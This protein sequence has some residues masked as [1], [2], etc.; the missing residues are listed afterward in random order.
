MMNHIDRF[1]LTIGRQSVDRSASWLGR[2]EKRAFKGL[3]EY[4]GVKTMEELKS[5][6]DDD[7]LPV[8]LPYHSQ[9]GNAVYAAFDFEKS[10]EGRGMTG[11]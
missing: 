2:P 9:V 1:Y 5:K 6:V 7:I 8:E 10:I 11:H 3:F 4:F